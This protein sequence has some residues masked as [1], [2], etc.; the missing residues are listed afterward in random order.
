MR[1]AQSGGDPFS[2]THFPH[3]ALHTRSIPWGLRPGS[4][5]DYHQTP[6]SL[7]GFGPPHS[8]QPPAQRATLTPNRRR[9]SNQWES[10]TPTQACLPPLA[11]Q[12]ETREL[13][14]TKPQVAGTASP[15]GSVLSSKQS[16]QLQAFS[17]KV[18]LISWL[19]TGFC[20]RPGGTLLDCRR[21]FSLRSL[22]GRGGI[23]G[24]QCTGKALN[25]F[26]AMNQYLI[27]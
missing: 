18:P 21:N 8:E 22:A 12:I 9:T 24:V 17:L 25:V 15:T 26:I 19:L 4:I 20:P 3:H 1:W 27:Q 16:Y 5:P 7:P 23:V 11:R 6:S 13:E 2:L 14:L 10:V